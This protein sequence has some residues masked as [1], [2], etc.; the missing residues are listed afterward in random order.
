MRRFRFIISLILLAV[1]AIIAW[2]APSIAK[3][4]ATEY[5]RQAGFTY[6]E[7]GGTSFGLSSVT[8]TNIK[9]DREGFDK[10]DTL[11]VTFD[12]PHFNLRDVAMDGLQIT[13]PYFNSNSLAIKKENIIPFLPP[14]ELIIK[15]AHADYA[16][17]FGDLRLETSIWVDGATNSPRKIRAETK[18]RQYQLSFDT[19]WKGEIAPDMDIRLDGEV[20]DGRI[21]MGPASANRLSGWLSLMLTDTLP[22]ISGQIDAGSADISGIPLKHVSLTAGQT[23]QNLSLI[24][25]AEAAGIEG[26]S[27]SADMDIS[28]V[29][30]SFNSNLDVKDGPAFFQRLIDEKLLTKEHL[31]EELKNTPDFHAAITFEPQKRFAGGPLPFTTTVTSGKTGK[32][33]L[34]GNLLIYPEKMDIRGTA[35]VSKGMVG[36]VQKLFSIPE[37]KIS[38]TFLRLDG[39]LKSLAKSQSE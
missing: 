24:F 31:T 32:K 22:Q 16:T 9:L 38:G 4:K 13:R 2:R 11:M 30:S 17:K 21:R 10:I 39:S 5:L 8:L 33:L 37:D 20:S 15:D 27:L 19:S 6:V 34:S 14:G 29:Q 7:I 1:L 25:R 23:G 28:P 35:E 26:T 18:A 36:P 12:L 3:D